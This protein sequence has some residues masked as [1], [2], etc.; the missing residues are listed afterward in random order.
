[1]TEWIWQEDAISSYRLPLIYK[2]KYER[3]LIYKIRISP[4]QKEYLRTLK[5]L[6]TCFIKRKK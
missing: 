6:L 3:I 4:K 5:V 2:D 1:M